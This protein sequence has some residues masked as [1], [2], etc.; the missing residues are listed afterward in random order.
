V[1]NPKSIEWKQWCRQTECWGGKICGDR[2][3]ICDKIRG[4][5]LLFFAEEMEEELKMEKGGRSLGHNLNITNGFTN[6]YFW[7]V[8]SV[9]I[10]ICKN[11]MSLYLFVFFLIYYF[12]TV[13]TLVYTNI[14]FPS[15]YTD[16]HNKELFR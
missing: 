2:T 7:R 16:G 4:G 8:Y 15:V 3:L 11:N 6:E 12:I 14:N 1:E 5:S 9:G 10:F 13:I